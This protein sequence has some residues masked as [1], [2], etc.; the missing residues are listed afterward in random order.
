[1]VNSV[2]TKEE[3]QMVFDYGSIK[4]EHKDAVREII[5]ILED[6][7]S[8]G[9]DVSMIILELKQKFNLEDIP[10]VDTKKSK[11][12][13]YTSGERIGASIQ[14][15]REVT[16][17]HGK[18]VRIPFIA[19]GADLDYLDEMVDRIIEKHEQSKK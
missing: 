17:E 12:Y 3:I 14:G 8:R 16:D 13:K 18:R 15:W 7:S 6:R 1:M 2:V 4:K 19:M 11:W 5:S 10:F 9:V